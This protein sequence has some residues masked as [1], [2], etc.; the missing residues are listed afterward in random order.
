MTF[1]FII[2]GAALLVAITVWMRLRVVARRLDRL[3]ESYWQLRYD[4]GQMKTHVPRLDAAASRADA[5]SALH[6]RAAAAAPPATIVPLA[7][8]RRK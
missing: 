2:A 7:S 4:I 3:T 5:A 8:L 1:P 6:P